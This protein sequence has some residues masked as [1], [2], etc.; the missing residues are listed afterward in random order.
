M[1]RVAD[2]SSFIFISAR[3]RYSFW[4]TEIKAVVMMLKAGTGGMVLVR[5]KVF[6]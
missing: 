5:W 1:N 2:Q 4:G 3:V 6:G